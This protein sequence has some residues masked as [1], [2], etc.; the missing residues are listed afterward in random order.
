MIVHR[1]CLSANG[2][3]SAWLRCLDRCASDPAGAWTRVGTVC[4]SARPIWSRHL[5]LRRRPARCA[6]ALTTV[7]LRTYSPAPLDARSTRR[8]GRV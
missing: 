6:Q 8:R 1:N 7:L 3:S 5:S 4:R 2:D